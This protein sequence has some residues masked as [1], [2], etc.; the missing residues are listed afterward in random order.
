MGVVKGRAWRDEASH[1]NVRLLVV[2][3]L[4]RGIASGWGNKENKKKRCFW[5]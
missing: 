3:Q 1:T 2:S 5:S 4:A